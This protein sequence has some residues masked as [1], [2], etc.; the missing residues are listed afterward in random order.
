MSRKSRSKRT[1]HKRGLPPESLVYTGHRKEAPATI[2][3]VLYND[4]TFESIDQFVDIQADKTLWLDIR[5]LSDTNLI[6]KTGEIFHIHPLALEDVLNTQQR[7]KLE[8][9]D[10]GLFFIV[11]HLKIDP[12]NLEFES[13]QIS[14]FAGKNFIISFQED[15]DD[16]FEQVRK[17]LEE[18]LGKIRKKSADYLMYAMLDTIVDGYYGVMDTLEHEVMSIE[19]SLHTNGVHQLAK[20]KIFKLKRLLSEV[21]HRILPLREAVT[22]Y[23]RSDSDIIDQSN[24][25][26]FR[27]LVDHVAQILD[28]LDSER[29][30]LANMEAFYQAEA[31]NKLNHVMRFLTI[32][33][34]IFIPLSFIAGIYGMNFDNMPEL[35]TQS[36]Y[37]ILL[38]V[39]FAVMVG[40]L[41]WF[42]HK[43]WI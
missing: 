15:P 18:G 39:M 16:S 29:D 30:M 12:D 32:I 36:G 26:Y 10:N 38:G 25:L 27:D 43:K 20:A 37:F 11:P 19:E 35:H 41:G 13:E 2:H 8:E 31:A 28:S 4:A 5:N 40:M 34:T 23:Y 17:R 14:F 42:R 1:A 24:R 33:S 22:R 21:K 3:A 6:A 7:A 9:F